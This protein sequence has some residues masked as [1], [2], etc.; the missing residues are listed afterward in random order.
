MTLTQWIL[1]TLAI[2]VIHFLGTWK[3]YKV[4]GYKSWQAAVPIYN[5]IIL[6]KII[7]RPLWWVI[8]LFIPTINLILFGVIWVE[9]LRSFGKNSAKDTFL[10][11]ITFGLYIYTINYS[12][13]PTHF[14]DRSLQA[15]TGLGETVSSILFA[16]V[17]ATIVHNYLIQPYIIPTGSLEK[18]LLIGDF[19][20]VSKFHYG[21]RAPMTAVSFPM[22]HDTIP[23]IK[24]KSYLKKPQLPYF[25]LPALQK[26]KR[27]DIVVF[28]WPA[29]T[30]RQFFVREKRVDKPIDKKSNYVKR[31]VGIPG[32]TLE[33]IDGFIHTNGIKNILPERAEVQYTF[34]AYAKKGVSSRK[35]LDEGFEDFDRIYKIE[36][37]TESSFQ[38]IIPYITGRRGTADNFYV[39][40]GSK[41]LPTDLIR[42]LGLRV[43]ETLEVDKQL[44]IT[45][46]EAD[47]LRKITW[48]DSVKQRI[49]SIK[50]PNESFFPN[51]IPYNWNEDNF[52]PLLIPKKEMSIELTRDNLPL[53]KKIIQEYEGNQLEL[54]PTQI[55]INGEIASTYT[56]K[57]DYYWMMGDNRHKSE[58]SRFWG[59]VPD[60][61]IVG[62]P[63]FIWFSIKGIN[64]GIKNWSIRWD[65]VFTTVDG[66]GE[67]RS[68]FPYF[69]VFVVLWQGY[70]FYRKRKAKA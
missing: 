23:V 6:M 70:V 59:F 49:N 28:S 24:T 62:K 3:L 15:K 27:N 7:K 22:V 11:I 67:R 66:P 29:D 33:I 30:V 52:G 43:S 16:I 54:T 19:L 50:V 68:Y 4:A 18:S 51:K 69:L 36:N 13:N 20:F 1:F 56:F 10:G 21:A 41:G 58:D 9:T 31:C 39:Y 46:E 48:I 37:I 61:H 38:Q 47:K 40:T 26:I 35:L 2:Q 57:K 53:Y 34:N 44:T 14:P 32:D 5:A 8:L 60:D 63:V 55:K 45:L 65:R 42:K 17:A 64:D 25:R 12:S